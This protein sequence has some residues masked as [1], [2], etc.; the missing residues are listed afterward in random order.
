MKEE[1]N[2]SRS[3]AYLNVPNMCRGQYKMCQNSGDLSLKEEENF[4]E[5]G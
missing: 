4:M 3:T 5:G 2:L 1:L